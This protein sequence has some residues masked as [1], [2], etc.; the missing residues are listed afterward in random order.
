ME[1]YGAR[2]QEPEVVSRA[3]EVTA[4]DG[5][6]S[7]DRR[8]IGGSLTTATDGPAGS[9]SPG[10][11]ARAGGPLWGGAGQGDAGARGR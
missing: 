4:I 9:F 5:L 2:A 6:S 3:G 10:G 1:R 7:N 8:A 11:S